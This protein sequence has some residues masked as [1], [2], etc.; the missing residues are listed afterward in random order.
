MR[1]KKIKVVKTK[2]IF[3]DILKFN[4]FSYTEHNILFVQ[5]PKE[6]FR[7]CLQ[8]AKNYYI[9]IHFLFRLPYVY[10]VLIVKYLHAYIKPQKHYFSKM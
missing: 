8:L 4:S 9:N 6:S 3:S 7:I 1:G 5:M 10:T 2:Y